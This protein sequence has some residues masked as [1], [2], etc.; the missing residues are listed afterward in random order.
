MSPRR[1]GKRG[2]AKAS[3]PRDRKRKS[4]SPRRNPSRPDL[5]AIL[6]RLS[7]ALSIIATATSALIRVQDQTGTIAAH[8][9]GEEIVTLEYGVRAL[10]GVCDELDVAY[11]FMLP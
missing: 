1:Q 2:K 9:V 4:K 11:R 6:D 3:E 10:R 7:K 5:D 8:E